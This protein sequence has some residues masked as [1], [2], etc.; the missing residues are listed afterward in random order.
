MTKTGRAGGKTGGKDRMERIVRGFRNR[1][2]LVLGDLMLDTYIWGSVS[3]IS[4]EAP[5]PVVEVGHDTKCLG[6]AGN[7]SRN[8][9][10]LGA[11]PITA[12]VVG[13]DAEGRWIKRHL[14]D[15]RGVFMDPNRPT[16]VKT[17][18]IAGH[19]QVV[20]FDR[21]RRRRGCPRRAPASSPWRVWPGGS[22]GRGRRA[23]S[24]RRSGNGRRPTAW[25]ARAAG[26][27]GASRLG[28]RGGHTGHRVPPAG[29]SGTRRG[30]PRPR[31]GRPRPPTGCRRRS[32]GCVPAARSPRDRANRCLRPET[33]RGESRRGRDTASR[34]VGRGGDR[35]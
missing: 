26:G 33:R 5:V 30:A 16:T 21:E 4:P 7:V 19:Q 18:V 32:V 3:R 17:R 2:V 29:E 1:Q 10:S 28:S 22:G 20:R 9:E 6:G 23:G 11:A 14:A 27:P 34:A 12:G 24:P 8:L 25:A 13:R 15:G 31:R 35:P